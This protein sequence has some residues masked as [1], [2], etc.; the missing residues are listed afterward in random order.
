MTS[1]CK[2][3]SSEVDIGGFY[4]LPQAIHLYLLHTSNLSCDD[5]PP[6][7]HCTPL[8]YYNNPPALRIHQNRN[9]LLDSRCEAARRQTCPPR[10]ANTHSNP[11]RRELIPH[12]QSRLRGS[13]AVRTELQT[14]GKTLFLTVFVSVW[15]QGYI[16]NNRATTPHVH[17]AQVSFGGKT[18][19]LDVTFS[20]V[21]SNFQLPLK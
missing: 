11:G 5:P 20:Q 6:P 2:N 3:L 12:L 7:P 16:P 1:V 10:G 15:N 17:S 18:V 13:E 19:I 21:Q 14:V 8:I 9:P 4:L